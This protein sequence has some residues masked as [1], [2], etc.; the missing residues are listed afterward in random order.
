MAPLATN[1]S[2]SRSRIVSAWRTAEKRCEMNST[3]GLRAPPSSPCRRLPKRR[4]SPCGP[5]EDVGS[6]WSQRLPPL[7]DHVPFAH[8]HQ[9]G[10]N[11][12][13]EEGHHIPAAEPDDDEQHREEGDR[14]TASRIVPLPGGL[15]SSS[16]G[17]TRPSLN[18][19][20]RPSLTPVRYDTGSSAL[21]WSGVTLRDHPRARSHFDRRVLCRRAARAVRDQRGDLHPSPACALLR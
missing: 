4:C 18:M 7:V 2:P 1:L 15:I 13:A 8:S 16:A 20:D 17:L 10:G 6:S 5:R 11:S 9:D 3:V 19:L 21:G 14:F 12:G